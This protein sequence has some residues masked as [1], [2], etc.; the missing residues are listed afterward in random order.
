M[1]IRDTSL[2]QC[3][4]GRAAGLT[5]KPKKEI[6]VAVKALKDDPS[7]EQKDE[8]FREVT[9]MSILAHPNIVRLLAVSTEE[10]PYGMV[11]EF[12][13][14]GDLNH[15]LRNAFPAAETPLESQEPNKG[16]IR[17]S[18]F[19]SIYPPIHPSV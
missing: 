8:F 1:N 5:E 18:V 16:T 2:Y 13:S 12:M 9:L 3:F 17:S 7:K 10:E 4:L 11:F 15:Y 6:L 19:P 14:S